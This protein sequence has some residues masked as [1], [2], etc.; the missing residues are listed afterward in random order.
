MSL[1]LAHTYAVVTPDLDRSYQLRRSGA[2]QKNPLLKTFQAIVDG[3]FFGSRLSSPRFF[4]S[5]WPEKQ[6][7][8][9]LRRSGRGLWRRLLK[10]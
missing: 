5:F 3:P 1:V 7:V 8:A 9:F 2:R 10:T 6:D 4:R